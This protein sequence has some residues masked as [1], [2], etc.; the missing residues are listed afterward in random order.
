MN[1]TRLMHTHPYTTMAK[2]R[3][4]ATLLVSVILLFLATILIITVSRTTLMEQRMAAN[5][6]RSRKAFEAAQAGI[7][8]AM[9]TMLTTGVDADNNNVADAGPSAQL[10]ASPETSGSR[11][12]V[13]FCQPGI[14]LPANVCDTI[15]A[16]VCTSVTPVFFNTPLVVSCG[17]SD[18]GIGRKLVQQAV[19]TVGGAASA[20]TNPLISKGAVNV[21]GSANVVNYFNNLSIWAGGSLT[22]IGNSGKSF[23]RNP[24]VAPPSPETVPPGPP[25]SCTT[26]TDYVCL[27]DKNTTGPDVIANDPTLANL[28][29]AQMFTNFTGQPDLATYEALVADRVIAANQANTLTGKMGE[30]IVVNG[31]T[32]LPNSTI[33][34]RDRPVV[35][36]VNGN[37]DLQGTPTVYGLVYITGNV[38]GGGNVTV[39]GSMVVQGVVQPTGSLDIIYDPLA[40]TRAANNTG[41][42][43]WIPGSWRDWR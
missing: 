17:W 43:G 10:W 11:Y 2:Q 15:A 39:Q 36:I 34:S 13:S 26:S 32:T 29:N 30:A 5:E 37:L 38:T 20:P 27:T 22:S 33:G 6:I 41:R 28:T 7:D 35:L 24:T 9:V 4:M 8:R 31:D 21:G 19:G 14:A 18:D 40:T 3:G 1:T 12:F 42:R 16:P 25:N 23:V